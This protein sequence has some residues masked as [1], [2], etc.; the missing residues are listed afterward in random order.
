M[1]EP[2]S[3]GIAAVSSIG[4]AV[5]QSKAS[6]KANRRQQQAANQSIAEQRRQFEAVQKLLNPYVQSGTPAL[7]GLMGIAGLGSQGLVDYGA[8]VQ[9]NPDLMAEFQRVGGQFGNDPAAFGEYHYNTFGKNEGRD[10]SPFT[11]GATDGAGAQDAAFRQ[12]EQS[13]GFQAMARQG[14]EA[15]MQNASATGGLRGGNTQ[16]ALARFRPALLDQFIERQFGRLSGIASAGQNAAVGVGQAG[17]QTGQNIGNTMIGAGQASAAN[18]GAQ[19][20][21][22]G[23]LFSQLGGMGAYTFGG[24]KTQEFM[25]PRAPNVGMLPSGGIIP[26]TGGGFNATLGRF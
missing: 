21:I 1:P 11:T 25:F 16:G 8:Y 18:A 7:Q 5:V 2:I 26:N 6:S 22:F 24:P 14:E 13:P 10:L 19:G 4:S 3:A 9:G 12:I 17:M 20:Q 23:S 15:I